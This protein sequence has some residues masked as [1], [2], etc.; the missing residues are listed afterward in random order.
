MDLDICQKLEKA[1]KQICSYVKT[2]GSYMV[3]VSQWSTIR[4]KL[5]NNYELCS[6]AKYSVASLIMIW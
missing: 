6:N 4:E 3:T 1:T 5:K 2:E